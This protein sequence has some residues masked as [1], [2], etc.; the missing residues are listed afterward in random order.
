MLRVRQPLLAVVS[1]VVTSTATATG[2]STVTAAGYPGGNANPLQGLTLLFGALY[3][4]GGGGTANAS[5][6]GVSIVSAEFSALATFDA[7]AVGSSTVSAVGSTAGGAVTADASATGSSTVSAIFSGL[8]TYDATATGSSTVTAVGSSITG[9]TANATATGSSTVTAVLSALGT[10]DASATG[11]STVTALF[12]ALATYTASAT[13]SSTVTAV[14]SSTGGAV[15]ADAS[16]IGFSTVEAAGSSLAATDASATGS[17]TVSAKTG[18]EVDTPSVEQKFARWASYRRVGSNYLR[19]VSPGV[20]LRVRPEERVPQ[21]VVKDKVV[22]PLDKL[23]LRGQ[24]IALGLTKSDQRKLR[25]ELRRIE[26][27]DKRI[28]KTC[29]TVCAGKSKVFARGGSVKMT[30][31]ETY[32]ITYYGL[33]KRE[34]IDILDQLEII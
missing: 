10:F 19:Q 4:A 30:P 25:K 32:V 7:A 1:A 26:L 22:G 8:A 24:A 27:D 34:L 17:S 6:T 2:S 12:S 13:G 33:T 15:A 23:S 11:S 16:A 29:G 28:V 31:E 21:V 3:G 18:G 5:A 14:G 9:A 20:F